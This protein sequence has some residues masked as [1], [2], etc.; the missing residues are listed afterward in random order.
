[1]KLSARLTIVFGLFGLAL[2][3]AIAAISWFIAA[4][5]IR[6][7]VDDELLNRAAVVEGVSDLEPEVIEEFASQPTTPNAV[8]GL[9]GSGGQVFDRSGVVLGRNSLDIPVTITEELRAGT[10]GFSTVDV[11]DRTYRVYTDVL[12]E[13]LPSPLAEADAFGVQI[14]QDVTSQESAIAGL[15]WQLVLL[16]FVG[17][18]LSAAGSWIVGQWLAAPVRQLTDAAERLTDPAAPPSRIEVARNDEIGQLADSFN[19]MASALEIGREQQQRLVADASHEL[20]TPL[21]S[22]RM[23]ADFLAS[24][25]DLRAEH[26]A[27]V[28]GAVV[29]VEQLTALVTDLIDL[30]TDT[31][32]ADEVS[33]HRRLRDIVDEVATRTEIAAQVPIHVVADDTSGTVYPGMVR[34][35]VQNLV[36]NAVKYAP[37]EPVTIEVSEGRITVADRGTGIPDEDLAHV[38]DRF[39]RSPRARSRPGNGIGL[40][41]VKQVAEI[42]D[43][44]VWAENVADGGARVGF[45][46]T[47]DPQ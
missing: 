43:G 37:D 28:D 6:A 32:A 20:R 16:G 35:A 29:D 18:G 3:T 47:A 46:V 21:T 17:V 38:F 14:F 8:F 25:P 41:I 7:S 39:F 24:F 19:R 23:R 4:N 27:I 10:A 22:L 2:V 5:E 15:A 33:E 45:S 42:H 11:G 30:A 26:R 1:M 44:E 31:R 34:R 12:P 40:A 13:N 9:E 36:D